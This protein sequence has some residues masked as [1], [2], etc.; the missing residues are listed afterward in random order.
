M[1]RQLGLNSCW[2]RYGSQAYKPSVV[3][4]RVGPPVHGG[5]GGRRVRDGGICRG[6]SS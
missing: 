3:E 6:T 4:T 2:A 1:G 5:H